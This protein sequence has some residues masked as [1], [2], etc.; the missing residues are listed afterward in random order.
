MPGLT[1][2]T[3]PPKAGT[4]AV[5][6][7]YAPGSNGL[8]IWRV[9][10]VRATE[11]AARKIK[12]KAHEKLFQRA[13]GFAVGDTFDLG[14]YYVSETQLDEMAAN[15]SRRRQ[16][17]K[18]YKPAT[19]Y[20]DEQLE[21]FTLADKLNDARASSRFARELRAGADPRHYGMTAD[22]YEASAKQLRAEVRAA[23][24]KPARNP[25]RG[26]GVLVSRRVYEIRYHHIEKDD[27]GRQD[28]KHTF[29]RGVCAEMLPDGSVRLYHKDGKP[30]MREY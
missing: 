29:G 2:F 1:V 9:R 24:G 22:E 11:Q 4:F 25:S 5:A 15:P 17:R 27:K 20:T 13:S 14:R 23:R 8:A 3:N 19:R 28:F 10:V 6:A 26:R 30:L 12:R 7:P 18:Q 16:P 21:R